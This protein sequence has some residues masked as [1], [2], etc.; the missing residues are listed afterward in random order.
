[1]TTRTTSMLFVLSL[2][3][4]S[5]LSLKALKDCDEVISYSQD[6]YNYFKK[7]YNSTNL[8]DAQ[9]YSKKGMNSA[10]DAE[11]SASDSNCDCSGAES[12]A[13]DAYSYGKKAYNS[14]KLS[15]AQY[16][17][18]KAMNAS[19]DIEDNADDCNGN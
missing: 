6:A 8:S 13:S 12:S 7:A 2:I 14:D 9:Y 11:E 15:D 3:S 16:Y 10:S 18:R 5:L 17:V 19:S 4:A 1:M